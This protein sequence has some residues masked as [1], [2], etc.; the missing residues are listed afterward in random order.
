M[1]GVTG[2]VPC[3]ASAMYRL[4][5]VS[6]NVK[7]FRVLEQISDVVIRSTVG[8]GDQ[9]ESRLHIAARYVVGLFMLIPPSQ[10]DPAA[11]NRRI[12]YRARAADQGFRV[13]RRVLHRRLHGR[14]LRLGD[15]AV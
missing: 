14:S 11:G 5:F 7:N 2:I 10:Y 1:V 9:R 12:V 13:L 4:C 15:V 6:V 8:A 3:A